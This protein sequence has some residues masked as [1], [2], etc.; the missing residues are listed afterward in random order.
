MVIS[1]HIGELDSKRSTQVFAQV[2]ADLCQLYRITPQ[3]IIC[4]AHPDY[5]SSRYA[6]DYAH[7]H[8]I[9]LSTVQHHK[10]HAAIVCGACDIHYAQQHD[11]TGRH[12]NYLVF[13][14]DGTGLGDDQ[15]IWGGEGFYGHAGHWQ[16]VAS[17]NPFYLQ[18]GDKAAREPWRSACALLWEKLYEDNTSAECSLAEDELQKQCIQYAVQQ[19]A[20]DEAPV[21]LAFHAWKKRL[22]T[23]QSSSMGRLFD[24]ASA[25]SGL[26]NYSSFEGQGPMLLEALL[27]RTEGTDTLLDHSGQIAHQLIHAYNDRHCHGPEK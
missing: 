24:A 11:T 23:I 4:D 7:T 19:L 20:M 25:L 16:R 1:P 10:A 21:A 8:K 12:K 22:N 2:I 27:A 18:G 17:I 13:T 3:H 15:S 6:R 14:W 9:P 26:G 5:Y